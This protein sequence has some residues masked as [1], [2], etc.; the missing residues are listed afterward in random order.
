[1]FAGVAAVVY[2]IWQGRNSS[3]W[4]QS[5]PSLRCTI[6]QIRAMVRARIGSVMPKKVS[7]KDHEWFLKL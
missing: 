3:Y 4:Q 7:R 5:I 1:M 6:K 2:Y